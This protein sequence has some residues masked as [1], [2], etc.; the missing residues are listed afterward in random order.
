[1]PRSS[2]SLSNNDIDHIYTYIQI[3]P[4]HTDNI[5]FIILFIF[6]FILSLSLTHSLLVARTEQKRKERKK[7]PEEG[8]DN[9]LVRSIQDGLPHLLNSDVMRMMAVKEI[10]YLGT[11][12]LENRILVVLDP[13]FDEIE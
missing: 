1:M 8:L 2:H 9:V 6:I 11:T 12:S 3:N 4:L 10:D 13:S 5:Y 7:L